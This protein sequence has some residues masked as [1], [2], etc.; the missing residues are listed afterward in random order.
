M[1]QFL[2]W[3]PEILPALIGLA[4]VATIS[5]VGVSPRDIARLDEQQKEIF[6]R[7]DALETDLALRAAID[8]PSVAAPA[9]LA[10]RQA[11]WQAAYA[12]AT[13]AAEVDCF[14]LVDAA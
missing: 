6:R 11:T 14:V 3:H 9:A 12:P 1:R 7:L 4:F 2:L 13:P 8:H 10:A 5:V